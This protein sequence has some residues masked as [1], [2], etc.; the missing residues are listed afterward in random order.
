MEIFQEKNTFLVVGETGSGKTTLINYFYNYFNGEK[1]C[2]VFKSK[3]KDVKLAVPNKHWKD[4]VVDEYKG[5][6]SEQNVDLETES[7]TSDCISYEIKVKDNFKI[8]LIDT[9]GFNNKNGIEFDDKTSKKIIQS[10]LI[11][12]YINGIFLVINGTSPRLND[13]T[14]CFIEYM[15]NLFPDDFKINVLVILTNCNDTSYNFKLNCLEKVFLSPK[16][17]YMQNNLFNWNKSELN[18][19]NWRFYSR[20]WA[21]S[22]DTLKE[23]I[24]ESEKMIPIKTE[25]LSVIENKQK[26]LIDEFKVEIKNSLLI[27]DAINDIEFKSNAIKESL[28]VKKQNLVHEKEFLIE[29][30]PFIIENDVI[31]KKGLRYK[32]RKIFNRYFEPKMQKPK[33][34]SDESNEPQTS[35]ENKVSNKFRSINEIMDVDE[36]NNFNYINQ[37]LLDVNIKTCITSSY[38]LID[39]LKGIL[40][41]NSNYID[42]DLHLNSKKEPISTES[43]NLLTKDKI[44]IC[45]TD[46]AKMSEKLNAIIDPDAHTI[47]LNKKSNTPK[48][49]KP[50]SKALP[51]NINLKFKDD[52]AINQCEKADMQIELAETEIQIKKSQIENLSKE[53]E[54]SLKKISAIII[55]IKCL[56]KEYN[57]FSLFH[58]VIEEIEQ[59]SQLKKSNVL[60]DYIKK[61]KLI[62]ENSNNQQ[63]QHQRLI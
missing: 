10:C 35:T 39:K 52:A 46:L 19:R 45:K 29:A 24:L 33:N 59:I 38:E 17:F 56:I 47:K 41:I 23:I 20:N 8:A 51:V 31:E 36:E 7:Q 30:I 5:K 14:K 60:D 55:E 22:C 25:L 32:F 53:L 57:F 15:L 48:L 34:F 18:D 12:E 3:P 1:D 28:L 58:P 9:P 43:K 63:P 50:M 21:D 27:I 2:S 37:Q 4:N 54:E 61:V 26:E 44:K 40:D 13:S 49:N 11:N 16:I 42:K 62:I 6:H